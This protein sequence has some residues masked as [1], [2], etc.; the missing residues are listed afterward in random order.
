M[1]N[2]SPVGTTANPHLMSTSSIATACCAA[3]DRESAGACILCNR[4]ICKNCRA[5]VNTKAVC[6]DCR[7]KVLAELRSEEAEAVHYPAAVG[8]GI[9]AAVLC[10]AAWAAMVVITD[11]EIGYAA[12]GVGFLV[13]YGV[14]L[15]ARKKRGRNLQWI[16]IG[17]SVLGLVLGKYF[18]VAHMIITHVEGAKDLS[19]FDPRLVPVFFKVLPSFLSP[20]DALWVFIALRVAWRIPKPRAVQVG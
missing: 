14:L 3:T 4:S 19:H 5:V 16:A 10:G 9:I 8:G 17:C 13:G 18:T 12:V 6:A 7:D 1:T 15:G 20:F 11:V 2:E